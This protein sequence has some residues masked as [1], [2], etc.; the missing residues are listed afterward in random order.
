MCCADQYILN[1]EWGQEMLTSALGLTCLIAMSVILGPR[2]FKVKFCER[3]YAEVKTI[4]LLQELILQLCF[5]YII[6]EAMYGV[7]GHLYLC[8][9][10]PTGMVTR[11]KRWHEVES[12]HLKSFSNMAAPNSSLQLPPAWTHPL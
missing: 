7:I 6:H 4:P 3:S 11:C 12:R 8:C 1:L 2:S 10:L 5:H 9:I